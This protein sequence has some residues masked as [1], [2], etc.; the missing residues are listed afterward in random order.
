MDIHNNWI[1]GRPTPSAKGSLFDD[2][3]PADTRDLIGRFQRSRKEDVAR[4]VAAAEAAL[5]AWQRR[6]APKRGEILFKS[7]RILEQRKDELAVALSR[8]MGKSPDEAAGDV[9]EAIDT[10]YYF[11][12]EGRRLFG[13]TTPSELPDKLCMTLRR[14]VGVCGLITPW[15]FPLAIPAW[16]VFPALICGNTLVLKP[17]EDTPLLS[18]LL[19]EILSD[20]GLPDG[21]FNVVTG[22]GEE[23]GRALVA[24]P[25]VRLISFTGSSCSGAE[26]AATCGAQLKRCSLE[27]GGKNALIVLEDADIPLALEAAL[28]GAFA[29]SGQRCTAT[30]RVLVQDKIYKKFLARFVERAKRSRLSPIINKKQLS[31]IDRHVRRA[32]NE[33]ARLV[34]GGGTDRSG[35]KRYGHFY[36]PTVFAGVTPGMRIAQEEVF[37]P[38]VSF[39]RVRDEDE[40][41]R[42]AN[43]SFYGLS[44]AVFTQDVSRALKMVE[45]LETG[46]TYVNSA[47]IGAE[48]HL[49]FGGV[50]G[51]G[52][53]HR[54]A[55]VTALDIFSEWKTVYL[56]H[57]GR[58][59]RAQIDP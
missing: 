46:I 36:K 51:T 43:H 5:P 21:A 28:W 19:A 48:A 8:E 58:L 27:L 40:A 33:G 20:A 45:A 13:Q 1:N 14:P 17:A 49:P 18:L 56:D 23:A 37:G 53:G 44:S 54:E 29:T 47:T 3:N 15:N 2:V 52:N 59:Q 16:K 10:A 31:S 22:F 41:V 55:G 42:V 57:S 32:Q 24:H 9:Q 25:S 12:G 7:A 35:D 30:S 34:L 26:I 6:P 11:A 4:A 39:I 50:K 38:V